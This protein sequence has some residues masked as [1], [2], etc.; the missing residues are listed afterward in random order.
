[1]NLTLDSHWQVAYCLRSR[2]HIDFRCSWKVH[3]ARIV[4][5]TR[6]ELRR[7]AGSQ[8][9][10]DE[11]ERE[12]FAGFLRG[13]PVDLTPGPWQAMRRRWEEF[14]TRHVITEPHSD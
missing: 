4:R 9:Y 3:K 14:G 10:D 5:W 1:M 12:E 6:L 8:R 7:V 11:Y 13:G 2:S